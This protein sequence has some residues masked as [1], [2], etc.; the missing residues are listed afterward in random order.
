MFKPFIIIAFLFELGERSNTGLHIF[1]QEYVNYCI[2]T[3]KFKKP[4]AYFKWL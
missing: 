2:V 1:T 3:N 4:F